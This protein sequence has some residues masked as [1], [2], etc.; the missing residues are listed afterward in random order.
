LRHPKVHRGRLELLADMLYDVALDVASLG[1]FGALVRRTVGLMDLCLGDRVLD[2]GCGTGRMACEVLERIGPEG[3]LLGLDA[4]PVMVERFRRRCR[5]FPNTSVKLARVDLPLPYDGEFDKVI[6]SFVLHELP[7]DARGR[8]LENAR[9]ALRDGGWIVVLDYNRF[10][11]GMPPTFE[12]FLSALEPP[13][14][15]EFVRWDLVSHLS[16]IGFGRFVEHT[17]VGGYVRLL[18]ARKP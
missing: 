18:K 9:R 8:A 16:G 11:D 1:R 13:C 12:F 7:K 14:A 6:F 17:L 15:L 4:S 2:M 10:L 3:R 5:R